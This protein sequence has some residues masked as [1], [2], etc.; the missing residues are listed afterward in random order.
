MI[1]LVLLFLIFHSCC[2]VWM[3]ERSVRQRGRG[4]E[5]RGTGLE[6]R[7]EKE[8]R[9][10]YTHRRQQLRFHLLQRREARSQ[11]GEAAAGGGSGRGTMGREEG[12][13]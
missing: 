13:G 5:R 3:L 7:G 4:L 9:G 1:L 10:V 11:E 2:P 6:G 12:G 8:R